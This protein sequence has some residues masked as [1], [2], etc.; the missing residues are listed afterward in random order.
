MSGRRELVEGT[1]SRFVSTGQLPPLDMVGVLVSE[2]YERYRSNTEGSNA[3]VYPA[4]AR[5]PGDLFGI[6]VAGTSGAVYS[7]GDGEVRRPRQGRAGDVQ[8]AARR[9]GQQPAGAA[10]GTVPIAAAGPR[11]VRV[12]AG[13]LRRR[14]QNHGS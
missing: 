9:S 11:S 1:G 14:T 4:L 2:A 13:G 7:V 10:R 6:C 8:P 3:Q 5:V 12:G